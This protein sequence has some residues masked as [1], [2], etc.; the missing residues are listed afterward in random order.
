VYCFYWKKKKII[1]SKPK[2]MICAS[3]G[4][5]G[6]AMTESMMFPKN[7]KEFLKDY[8]FVD[9]KEF[10]TNGSRLISTFRVEQMI[11]HYFATDTNDG[12]KHGHWIIRSSGRGRDVTNWAE[13]SECHVCGSPNWKVCPVCETRMENSNDV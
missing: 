2:N 4:Q 12:C 8:S 3:A 6:K 7:W 5:K 13:C 1:F 10:Y 9:H 11:E